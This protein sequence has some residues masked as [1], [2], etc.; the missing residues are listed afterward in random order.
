[1]EDEQDPLSGLVNDDGSEYELDDVSEEE[2]EGEDLHHTDEDQDAG[3]QEGDDQ[4]GADAE[5]ALLRAQVNTTHFATPVGMSPAQNELGYGLTTAEREKETLAQEHMRDGPDQLP[6][7]DAGETPHFGAQQMEQL[8]ASITAEVS[9][10]VASDIGKIEE[11][12][13]QVIARQ[14][15]SQTSIMTDFSRKLQAETERNIEQRRQEAATTSPLDPAAMP[16]SAGTLHAET[17]AGTMNIA[18]PATPSLSP[19][20]IANMPVSGEAPEAAT[21]TG[22]TTG[23]VT[24][25]IHSVA[26]PKAK[27][28][29][30]VREHMA[31]DERNVDPD[32]LANFSFSNLALTS[33]GTNTVPT[34]PGILLST[35][36]ATRK[37]NAE[38]LLDQ[39]E[40]SK[41][42]LLV[43]NPEFTKLSDAKFVDKVSS[44]LVSANLSTSKVATTFREILLELMGSLSLFK[45]T[46]QTESERDTIQA[47][48][49]L[50]PLLFWPSGVLRLSQKSRPLSEKVNDAVQDDAAGI[51]RLQFL[52]DKFRECAAQPNA[53]RSMAVS[54]LTTLEGSF[55][56][57]DQIEEGHLHAL[58]LVYTHMTLAILGGGRF[59][60]TPFVQKIAALQLVFSKFGDVVQSGVNRAV[61][62][63]PA[64]NHAKG[65]ANGLQYYSQQTQFGSK[66]QGNMPRL[67][68][69]GGR[70]PVS[71]IA[72]AFKFDQRPLVALV[73]SIGAAK[74]Q[75][76]QTQ[77]THKRHIELRQPSFSFEIDRYT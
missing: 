22:S 42:T 76:N 75:G 33:S 43:D 17:M 51:H 45:A 13:V 32:E 24:S 39:V 8:R 65:V 64:H 12:L 49:L 52:N 71:P 56:I 54:L 38:A 18:S 31:Q 25:S 2:E 3:T 74:A 15:Q 29:L 16:H 34:A 23:A 69:V 6:N 46:L 26:D 44:L 4:F 53:V 47:T 62:E 77:C 11:R 63:N 7:V 70:V 60:T 48:H 30:T 14:L 28:I 21:S 5:E 68:E 59:V 61:S 9:E 36:H 72:V 19:P 58:E 37:A 73:L 1:M 40:K 35:T 55:K 27:N 66:D 41:E 20:G 67:V 10:K 57:K 50:D